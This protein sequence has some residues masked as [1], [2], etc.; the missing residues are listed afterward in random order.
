MRSKLITNPF[1]YGKSSRLWI[2]NDPRVTKVGRYI[3]EH[4]IDEIP[5]LFNVLKGDMSLVGPRPRD[6]HDAY[7]ILKNGRT[8][9]FS[10]PPGITGPFQTTEKRSMDHEASQRLND[11]YA[12][13]YRNS[14]SIWRDAYYLLKTIP[15]VMTGHNYPSGKY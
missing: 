3:R 8:D 2:R 7:L 12:Y 1:S 5:Q 14:Y 10:C 11:E 15:Y 4:C 9:R 6:L 13:S